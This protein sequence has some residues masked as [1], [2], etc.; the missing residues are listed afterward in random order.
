[1]TAPC[2]PGPL[3]GPLQWDCQESH[4]VLGSPVGC[5][6]SF[7]SAWLPA[8]AWP[9]STAGPTAPGPMALMVLA[10]SVLQ[11][12][13]WPWGFP[14][15]GWGE[16]QQQDVDVQVLSAPCVRQGGHQMVDLCQPPFPS[17]SCQWGRAQEGDR[18]WGQ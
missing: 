13:H 15:A 18:G 16:W 9:R 14:V 2:I 11:E 5:P 1:M 10:L 8:T 12:G 7:P 6:C 3:D 17:W 4:I